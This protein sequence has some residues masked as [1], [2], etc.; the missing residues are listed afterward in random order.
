M[1][2]SPCVR[3]GPPDRPREAMAVPD[4]IGERSL[5]PQVG[6]AADHVGQHSLLSRFGALVR[7]RRV[8]RALPGRSP[9][10]RGGCRRRLVRHSHIHL[11]ACLRQV[12][13]SGRSRLREGRAIH[14]VSLGNP[15]NLRAVRRTRQPA[16]GENFG[17]SP[18]RNAPVPGGP[19]I[20]STIGPSPGE[21][22]RQNRM[23]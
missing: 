3:R 18:A 22:S 8:Y 11:S 4:V 6:S 19:S 2:A 9:R 15:Y 20:S 12:D 23:N 1:R 14:G 7:D 21:T 5:R 17:C 10:G 16:D 13:T